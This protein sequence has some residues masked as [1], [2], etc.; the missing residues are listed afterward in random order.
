MVSHNH[1][2]R[3]TGA[4]SA[5]YVIPRVSNGGVA[6][7]IQSTSAQVRVSIF[8]SFGYRYLCTT[9]SSIIVIAGAFERR[10]NRPVHQQIERGPDSSRQSR[11][12]LPTISTRGDI[13]GVSN[14]IS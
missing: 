5:N 11:S 13:G 12:F 10:E 14:F 9:I 3:P 1:Y 7:P 6:R 4:P 8:P 2:K